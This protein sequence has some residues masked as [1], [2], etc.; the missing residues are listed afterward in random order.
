M[1]IKIFWEFLI[2]I[3]IRLL[4]NFFSLV[5]IKVDTYPYLPNDSDYIIKHKIFLTFRDKV[6]K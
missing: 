6:L 5:L 4:S 1:C 2:N 3:L